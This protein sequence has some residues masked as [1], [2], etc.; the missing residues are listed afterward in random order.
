M[1]NLEQAITIEDA[2]LWAN[3]INID[4]VETNNIP[5]AVARMGLYKC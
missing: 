4:A 1:T 2:S 3:R 5:K